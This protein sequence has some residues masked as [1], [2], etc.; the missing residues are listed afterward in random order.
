MSEVSL[1]EIVFRV[2]D[3][4]DVV[5]DVEANIIKHCHLYCFDN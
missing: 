5:I 2:Y 1:K 4:V 3:I